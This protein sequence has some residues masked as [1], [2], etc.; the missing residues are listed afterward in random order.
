MI[1]PIFL[2]HLGCTDRCI[3]CDQGCI[4]DVHS[5]D[6][7]SQIKKSL[8]KMTGKFEVG[9]FG[10]NIFNVE[11]STLKMLFQY[12]D[13]FS[14]RILNFKIST[15]P[16][17]LNDETI[18]ILKENR[19]TVVELGMPVFND[20]MLKK[21]NRGHTIED[22][23][24]AFYLL[25]NEGFHVALQVMV[26]LPDETMNDI[27]ETTRQIIRLS[28]HYIR[29][30]PLVVLKDTPLHR[31][32]KEGLFVPIQFEEAIERATHIYL[33]ALRHSIK[34]VKMGLT[35]N[36]LIKDSIVAGQFHPAFGY[37]VKS[38]AFYLAIKTN[39]DVAAIKGD[40]TVKLNS[41][42]IP[43]LI[44][45]KRVNI[46]RFKE[47]GIYVTWEKQDIEK[48]SFILCSG[49]TVI[50]GIIFDALSTS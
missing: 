50:K 39:I 11:P 38:Q 30:Y 42:D 49:P 41:A 20:I 23:Y 15:K 25:K 17:P 43:H 29:I 32:H 16:T 33:N 48:G 4:T 31:M 14:E 21:L 9:L 22:F 19:V 44:G 46:E 27:K 10:G 8:E 7:P 37:M 36:E 45:H 35:A 18:R 40:V 12:F 28:P 3:Y 24:R 6:L 34:T 2:P 1:V 47:Q 13:N 5:H 26:G